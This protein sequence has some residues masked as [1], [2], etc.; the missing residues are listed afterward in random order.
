MLPS[1]ASIVS[2]KLPKLKALVQDAKGNRLLSVLEAKWVL[3]SSQSGHLPETAS[4]LY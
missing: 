4:V 1:S 2:I 3:R